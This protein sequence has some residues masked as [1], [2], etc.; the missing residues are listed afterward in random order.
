MFANNSVYTVYTGL[1]APRFGVEGCH[2]CLIV[3]FFVCVIVNLY[4]IT[5]VIFV[6][7]SLCYLLLMTCLSPW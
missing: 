7:I 3:C 1:V 5:S 4:E 6:I 2:Y